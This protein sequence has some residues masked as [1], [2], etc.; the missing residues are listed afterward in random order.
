MSN[1]IFATRALLQKYKKPNRSPIYNEDINAC[2]NTSLNPDLCH[3]TNRPRYRRRYNHCN[4]TERQTAALARRAAEEHARLNDAIAMNHNISAS[5]A[6]EKDNY[7]HLKME[8]AQLRLLQ[9]QQMK[10]NIRHQ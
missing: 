10:Q 3:Q 8:N 1:N 5:L 6:A 9:Q 2:Y 7:E 4:Q